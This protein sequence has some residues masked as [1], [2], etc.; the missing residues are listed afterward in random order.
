MNIFKNNFVLRIN[1]K[2]KKLLIILSS[3][4]KILIYSL[5]NNIAAGTEHLKLEKLKL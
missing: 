2:L 1:I 5:F 4:D 3:F